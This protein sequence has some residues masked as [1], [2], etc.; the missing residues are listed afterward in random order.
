MSWRLAITTTIKPSKIK[1][2][3]QLFLLMRNTIRMI[4]MKIRIGVI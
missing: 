4:I 2:A 3:F 1:K